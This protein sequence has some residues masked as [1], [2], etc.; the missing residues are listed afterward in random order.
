MRSAADPHTPVIVGAGQVVQRDLSAPGK[1][2]SPQAL[3]AL[4]VRRALDDTGAGGDLA[5]SVDTLFAVR[6]FPDS[7]PAWPQPFGA[8]D[9]FP[10]SVATRV[11]AHPAAAVYTA[12][13]GDVPQATVARA[14]G[15]LADGDAGCVVICG[16]EALA[17]VAAAVRAGVAPD[18]SESPGGTLTDEGSGLHEFLDAEALRH[19]LASAPG[20]YALFDNARRRARRQ[21]AADYLREMAALFS[22]LS[23]IAARNPYAMFPTAV[24]AAETAT[25]AGRNGFV[26]WPYTRA[27]CARD[28]VNQA[29]ALVMTTAGR[30]A[31]FGIDPAR[32]VFPHGSAMAQEAPLSMRERLDKSLSITACYRA[33]LELAE[34]VDCPL[35]HLDLYSCFPIAV[36]LAQEALGAA[37]PVAVPLSV[38]GGLP[39]FGGPG[40]SYSLHAIAETVVRLRGGADVL[41]VVG[42]N[43]GVLSKQAVGL[44]G[45]RPLYRA[46]NLAGDPSPQGSAVPLVRDANGAARLETWTVLHERG[47][48][49]HAVAVGRLAAG[50][51]RCFAASRE[52]AVLARL[53]DPVPEPEGIYVRATPAGNIFE[54]TD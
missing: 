47:A 2:A 16:A 4:A 46:G 32:A 30:L 41:A 48:P 19:G 31:E 11:G 34:E 12:A 52:P 49:V 25:P 29:A 26:A 10:R 27:L 15:L 24:S 38:T 18:W 37:R 1:L 42:A 43:G 22:P 35:G 20:L 3:A 44:Y 13:G 54:L 51:G 36:F 14:A 6:T 39:Y 28:K 21:T 23:E 7:S 33:I 17:S 50:G 53:T 9:N 40:N 8:T 5:A 45:R